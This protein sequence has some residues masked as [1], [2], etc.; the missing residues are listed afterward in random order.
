MGGEV[1]GP[2]KAQYLHIGEFEAGEAGMGGWG[3]TLR[4]WWK[5]HGIGGFLGVG[6]LESGQHLK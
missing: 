5:R 6:S 1:F 2:V 4:S 3:S